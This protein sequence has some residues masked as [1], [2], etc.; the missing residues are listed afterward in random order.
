MR[1]DQPVT[2]DSFTTKNYSTTTL[3]RA[4][5]NPPVGMLGGSHRHRLPVS[6]S[7]ASRFH[8]GFVAPHSG[9][10]LPQLGMVF[11]WCCNLRGS[12]GC[13]TT[14]GVE[15]AARRACH[16]GGVTTVVVVQF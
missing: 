9:V 3:L 11:S 12:G 4:S 7:E 15:Q 1:N 5:A 8:R 2:L 13:W 6:E 14:C 16:R 10:A